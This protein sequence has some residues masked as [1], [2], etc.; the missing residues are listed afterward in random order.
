METR[1]G[2]KTTEFWAL[3][4]LNVLPEIG[5]I[6]VGDARIKG[7]L[8]IVTF[9]AYAIARGLAKQGVPAEPEEPVVPVE[10]SDGVKHSGLP[11]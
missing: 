9:F 4:V 10:P 3:I 11:A 6:D 1:N 5:A 8:H 2:L 7:L